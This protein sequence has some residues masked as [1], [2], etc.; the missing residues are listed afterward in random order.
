MSGEVSHDIARALFAFSI[1]LQ[2]KVAP[3]N[4][5]AGWEWRMHPGTWN[6]V[7]V[8]TAVAQYITPARTHEFSSPDDL[9]GCPVI[10][11][12]SLPLGV[13]ELRCADSMML[14]L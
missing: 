4:W 1:N 8:D 6:R 5:P 7:R 11:D 2:Q 13:V 12:A 3:V 10:V 14:P 9:L